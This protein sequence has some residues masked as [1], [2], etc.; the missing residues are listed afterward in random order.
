MSP[1]NI[2]GYTHSNF[3]DVLPLVLHLL[4]DDNNLP[5]EKLN[6]SEKILLQVQQSNYCN[7][8]ER[9]SWYSGYLKK[10]DDLLATFWL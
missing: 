10:N 6:Q 5:T 3:K 8:I 4:V 7:L 9:I 1:C 2:Y